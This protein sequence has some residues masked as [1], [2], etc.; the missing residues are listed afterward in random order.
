MIDTIPIDVIYEICKYI[1]PNDFLNFVIGIKLERND[2]YKI[3]SKLEFLYKEKLYNHG[4]VYF[5]YEEDYIQ[6]IL[7]GYVMS[8]IFVSVENDDEYIRDKLKNKNKNIKYIY[9][10][11]NIFGNVDT[12]RYEK[13]RN[14]IIHYFY[15][16]EYLQYIYYKSNK[17]AQ[18]TST[19]IDNLKYNPS[20][21]IFFLYSIH[22]TQVYTNKE[23]LNRNNGIYD[24]GQVFTYSFSNQIKIH[25]LF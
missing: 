5:I 10:M 25:I 8:C 14:Y 12:Q 24:F 20:E 9:N 22:G 18:I 16:K 7:S 23:E 17:F 1:K 21:E 4:N 19:I 6:S 3:S 11:K 15:S 13:I 2:I